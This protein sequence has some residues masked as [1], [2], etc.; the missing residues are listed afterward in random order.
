MFLF[1]KGSIIWLNSSK[2]WQNGKRNQLNHSAQKKLISKKNYRVCSFKAILA[3]NVFL[4]FPLKKMFFETSK[5]VFLGQIK[6]TVL[7]KYP[8]LLICKLSKLS[9]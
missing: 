7:K 4:S 1:T 3:N 2:S 6:A 8:S 9:F 5:K